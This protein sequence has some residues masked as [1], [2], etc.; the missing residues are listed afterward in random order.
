MGA[1]QV[2]PGE[3]RL[4]SCLSTR[5]QDDTMSPACKQAISFLQRTSAEDIRLNYKL[6]LVRSVDPDISRIVF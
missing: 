4:M 3:G 2:T 1:K 5:L 6:R